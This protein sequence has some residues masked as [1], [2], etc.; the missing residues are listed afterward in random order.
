MTRGPFAY[1]FGDTVQ[2]T[3]LIAMHTLGHSFVPAPIH[4]IEEEEKN[5]TFS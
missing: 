2:T 4:G 5:L 3:P 1:D